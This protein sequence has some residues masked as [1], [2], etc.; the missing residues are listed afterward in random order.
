MVLVSAARRRA[1][2]AA[3]ASVACGSV[4]LVSSACTQKPSP[5]AADATPPSPP[6]APPSANAVIVEAPAPAATDAGGDAVTDAGAGASMP[7]YSREG[8]APLP[9]DCSNPH[10]LLGIAPW[11]QGSLQR[12]IRQAMAAH[13]EIEV[14]AGEPGPHQVKLSVSRYATTY[15]ARQ[16]VDKNRYAVNASCGDLETCLA[17]A[18]MVRAVVPDVEPALFCGHPSGLS[19]DGD[20]VRGPWKLPDALPNLG[21]RLEVCSRVTTCSV[22]AAAAPRDKVWGACS[23]ARVSD[24]APCAGMLDCAQVTRCFRELEGF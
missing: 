1:G 5:P 14:V 18:A 8:I 7:A 6:S 3:L 24:V 10:A 13:P 11:E 4:F 19:S 21:D 23:K 2:I 22:R 16:R 12:R 15:F 17:V 20:P 9:P